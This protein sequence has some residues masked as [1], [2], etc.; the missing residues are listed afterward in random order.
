MADV[1]NSVGNTTNRNLDV[2]QEWVGV[3]E[4]ISNYSMVR[5]WINTPVNALLTIQYATTIENLDPGD[6]E[7]TSEQIFACYPGNHSSIHNIKKANFVRIKVLNTSPDEQ[8]INVKTKYAN[9]VPHPFLHYTNDNID[10]HVAV[11]LETITV[12]ATAVNDKATSSIT[13]YGKSAAEEA[14]GIRAITVDGG[15]RLNSNIYG[16]QDDNTIVQLK[17]TNDGRLKVQT[18]G[19]NGGGG[20]GE[21]TVNQADSGITAYGHT[22]ND[23]PVALL[24]EDDGTLNVTGDVTVTGTVAATISEANSSV[25]VYAKEGADNAVLQIANGRLL[26]QTEA[27]NGGDQVEVTNLVRVGGIDND[28]NIRAVKV[29]DQGRLVL[30]GDITLSSSIAING[31][32]SDDLSLDP[33]LSIVDDTYI[34]GYTYGKDEILRNTQ[35]TIAHGEYTK[36][37]QLLTAIQDTLNRTMNETIMIPIQ[38]RVRLDSRR[39]SIEFRT[40]YMMPPV[41]SF[42]GRYQSLYDGILPISGLEPLYP[43]KNDQDHRTNKFE[44]TVLEGPDYSLL[45]SEYPF[46]KG[47]GIIECKYDVSGCYPSIGLSLFPFPSNLGPTNP[48]VMPHALWIQAVDQTIVVDQGDTIMLDIPNLGPIIVNIDPASYITK[49]G[50]ANELAQAITTSGFPH[51]PVAQIPAATHMDVDIVNGQFRFMSTA[52]ESVPQ[53]RDNYAITGDAIVTLQAGVLR[54]DGKECRMLGPVLP[55][56]SYS[57]RWTAT[58][59]GNDLVRQYNAGVMRTDWLGNQPWHGIEVDNDGNYLFYING[60]ILIQNGPVLFQDNDEILINRTENTFG[61][62]IYDGNGV[63]KYLLNQALTRLDLTENGQ[64]LDLLSPFIY[65]PNK[66]GLGTLD[67]P[68]IELNNFTATTLSSPTTASTLSLQYTALL[69]KI[70]FSEDQVNLGVYDVTADPAVLTGVLVLSEYA[71]RTTDELGNLI[72]GTINHNPALGDTLTIEVF[73]PDGSDIHNIRLQVFDAAG[74]LYQANGF[75]N[76]Q[77]NMSS[78]GVTYYPIVG[79]SGT[80]GYTTEIRMSPDPFYFTEAQYAEHQRHWFPDEQTRLVV[81]LKPNNVLSPYLNITDGEQLDG[82]SSTGVFRGI[83]EVSILGTHPIS[84]SISTDLNGNIK[85]ALIVSGETVT[86]N[87]RLPVN[88]DP[89]NSGVKVYGT[90]GDELNGHYVIDD[91]NNTLKIILRA[92]DFF[93]PDEFFHSCTIDRGTYITATQL[94]NAF[95]KALNFGAFPIPDGDIEVLHDILIQPI[96]WRCSIDS[97]KLK[98]QSLIFNQGSEQILL[99]I[100]GDLK[101]VGNNL[102]LDK[103]A[104]D[105]S[106]Y[107]T[108]YSQYPLSKSWLGVGCYYIGEAMPVMGIA[109]RPSADENDLVYMV[110]ISKI[111]GQLKYSVKYPGHPT[112]VLHGL[113][114]PTLNDRLSI[115]KYGTNIYILI[116]NALLI[117]ITT[118]DAGPYNYDTYYPVIHIYND[119]DGQYEPDTTMQRIICSGVSYDPFFYG[120]YYPTSAIA[121]KIDFDSPALAELLGFDHQSITFKGTVIGTRP[122]VGTSPSNLLMVDSKGHIGSNLIYNDMPLS[123]NNRL[124][125]D[126]QLT[127]TPVPIIGTT[128]GGTEANIKVDNAGNLYASLIYD[129]QPV[130]VGNRL[131]VDISQANSSVLVYGK[132][133]D[134]NTVLQM[135]DGRLLVRTDGGEVTVDPAVSGITVYGMDGVNPVALSADNAGKLNV[136]GDVTVTGQVTATITEADSSVLVYGKQGETNTVLQMA[137]GRLLVRTEGINDGGE[138]TIDPAVSGIKVYGMDGTD[139]IALSVDGTGKLNVSGD[140][141]IIGQ[142]TATITEAD[143]SVLVYGKQGGTNTALQMADG[144]LLVRTECLND[145]GE[146]TVDPTVSGITVYGMDGVN[147]VALSADGTGKLNVTGQVTTTITETNSSVLVYGKQGDTNTVLQMADGRLLVRD[148]GGE[149]TVDPAVSGIKVYG[150]DGV[151]PVVLSVDGTGKLN[152]INNFSRQ[153]NQPVPLS[154]Y[155]A[156]VNPMDYGV[157]VQRGLHSDTTFINVSGYANPVRLNHPIWPINAPYANLTPAIGTISSSSNNDTNSGGIGARI[158][159]VDAL[160]AAGNSAPFQFLMTGTTSLNTVATTI[161]AINDF[162]VNS[163]GSLGGADGTITFAIGATT[164]GVFDGSTNKMQNAIYTVPLG[165]RAFI[166]K[167]IVDGRNTTAGATCNIGLFI[168]P[169]DGVFLNATTFHLSSDKVNCLEKEFSAPLVASA[170]SVIMMKC[171]A[172]T[173]GGS[174]EI[175]TNFSLLLIKNS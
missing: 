83:E 116:S 167:V 100:N 35:K 46:A 74:N 123:F 23:D 147:P 142:V 61:I 5:V 90:A 25:L 26:V 149:V 97:G 103:D 80:P 111:D 92:D 141:T 8:T 128:E 52:Y 145:G 7:V 21:V 126:A 6:V 129:G 164:V 42:G 37:S 171:T 121:I 106:L 4:D 85:T 53:D 130:A 29:D 153:L 151:N 112:A 69:P 22:D 144:R 87:N 131:P 47:A 33:A 137:D 16:V 40:S 13:V 27:I 152:V 60:P 28:D 175:T 70:G 71:V 124:P 18:E 139:P 107:A 31:F 72:L 118:I 119:V 172:I 156:V 163:A 49:I 63:A 174:W 98:I 19:I 120:G 51:D 158:V 9:K 64:I 58:T 133:G 45:C 110:K 81:N 168:R 95:E 55:N 96:Q 86:E 134:V 11:S 76:G 20:G 114:T 115:L 113:P 1:L 157:M 32:T 170:R 54:T 2:N 140:V 12:E 34:I 56:C 173:G 77:V 91:T 10:A 89:L 146:V 15:G 132:Q 24:V 150:M 82:V 159:I 161:S 17:L 101:T 93:V 127:I 68:S 36:L 84:K 117:P 73:S 166:N 43:R 125:V 39:V 67:H 169:L 50:L 165:Y 109:T 88:L 3:W 148:E 44:R 38:W 14:N 102:Y 136:T 41:R 162:Y 105:P 155:A 59:N 94:A 135:A 99:G 65:L 122:L 78:T 104:T 79:L 75:I 154:A 30:S 160:D 138:V 143:S 62:T 66:D 57:I 108:A 48:L